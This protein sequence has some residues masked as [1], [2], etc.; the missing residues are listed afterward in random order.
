MV[1]NQNGIETA[2]DIGAQLRAQMGNN[3][4]ATPATPDP[5]TATPIVVPAAVPAD[6]NVASATPADPN[7]TPATP[8]EAATP[9]V[10]KKFWEEDDV[11]AA[12]PATS[13]PAKPAAQ[14]VADPDYEKYQSIIKDPEIKFLIDQRLAGKSIFD[15]QK[16]IEI[17]DFKSMSAVDVFKHNLKRLG[18]TDDDIAE[19]VEE[20]KALRTF[21][22]NEKVDHIRFQLDQAQAQKMAQLNATAQ[23]NHQ[24]IQA[25]QAKINQDIQN[26]I[27]TLKGS[28]LFDLELS[29]DMI[30]QATNDVVNGMS[31]LKNPDGTPNIA[32]H[33][34]TALLRRNFK[35][36]VALA[37]K[38]A[39]AEGGREVAAEV[40]NASK[41]VPGSSNN[42]GNAPSIEEVGRKID[43]QDEARYARN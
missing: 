6:P 9:P 5:N 7:A 16:E 23:Q 13:D 41:N 32:A 12:T 31:D 10:A 29:E 1:E 35:R 14:P 4:P 30:N 26:H 21:E 19:K 2:E 33:Y 37:V 17:Q 8:A 34:E 24:Q 38:N 27:S 43:S 15:I 11:P 20:F 40:T 42:M 3:T 25:Q 39:K 22:Q 28:K 36:I 18:A